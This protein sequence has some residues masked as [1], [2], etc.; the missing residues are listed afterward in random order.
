[1]RQLSLFRI[2]YGIVSYNFGGILVKK[3]FF[4]S[5]ITCLLNAIYSFAFTLPNG[6]EASISRYEEKDGRIVAVII[7]KQTNFAVGTIDIPAESGSIVR[8]YDSGAIQSISLTNMV[9]VETDLGKFRTSRN[10]TM[11]F[12]EN[13]ALKSLVIYGSSGT[14]VKT[15]FGEMLARG[16][17]PVTFYEDGSLESLYPRFGQKIAFLSDGE[18]YDDAILSFYPSGTIKE[19]TP[20]PKKMPSTMQEAYKPK[21]SVSFYPSGNIK[22]FTPDGD[23][24][25]PFNNTEYFLV[26]GTTLTCF[27]TVEPNQYKSFTI[28]LTNRTET[29]ENITISSEIS[30]NEEM[31]NIESNMRLFAAKQRAT[32]D[33]GQKRKI[34]TGSQP[35]GITFE[36]N[37]KRTVEKIF[38]HPYTFSSEHE[39]ASNLFSPH[40]S[41]LI[42]GKPRAAKSAI[43]RE[44][45][46]LES[47]E[48]H[49]TL[50]VDDERNFN[51]FYEI[52][53][54]YYSA[55]GEERVR[56][57]RHTYVDPENKAKDSTIAAVFIFEKESI[58]IIS[59]PDKYLQNIDSV[60]FTDDGEVNEIWMKD[61]NGT[62]VEL[63]LE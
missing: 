3:I 12:Y 35:V 15:P 60:T 1:M 5:V 48:Y 42:D 8:F 29:I 13:G 16:D 23:V 50:F 62:L 47:V 39:Y 26:P 55:D 52:L 58:T 54:S 41:I 33:F 22:T 38:I 31:N 11:H 51:G 46:S 57:A 21:T 40:F 4:I 17:M 36:L 61:E 63:T 43:L 19:F 14:K 10:K 7:S 49:P 6:Q 59:C 56:V 30:R 9:D 24:V 27:D 20:N 37:E 25:I 53:R 2:K 34:N 32:K 28:D 18:Y 44:D 45:G